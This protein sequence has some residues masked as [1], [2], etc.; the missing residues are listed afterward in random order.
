MTDKHIET[1]LAQIGNR[2]D[3]SYGAINTPLYFSTAYKH[4]V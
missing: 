3:K 2:S 1:V 4:L